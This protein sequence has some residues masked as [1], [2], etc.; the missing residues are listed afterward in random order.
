MDSTLWSAHG[1]V[2]SRSDRVWIENAG[3]DE[4][5][6]PSDGFGSALNLI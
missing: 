6:R 2:Q 4:V 1:R 5:V 3:K